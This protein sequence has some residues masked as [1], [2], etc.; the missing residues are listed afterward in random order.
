MSV[1]ERI[2][3]AARRSVGVNTNGKRRN[4]VG[5]LS[6]ARHDARYAARVS[7]S[8]S[9]K[10]AGPKSNRARG[11]EDAV[12]RWI[13]DNHVNIDADARITKLVGETVQRRLRDSRDCARVLIAEMTRIAANNFQSARGR[14]VRVSDALDE[15]I[16]EVASDHGFEGLELPK[17]RSGSSSSDKDSAGSSATAQ[18]MEGVSDTSVAATLAHDDGGD[19]EDEED[20]SVY[21]GIESLCA[22]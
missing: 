13:D 6:R 5:K 4:R 14:R 16:E 1:F 22:Q 20:D 9:S 18:Q 17:Q 8:S 2:A 15:Y 11:R 10:R 12:S 21:V 3:P 19:N 7:S